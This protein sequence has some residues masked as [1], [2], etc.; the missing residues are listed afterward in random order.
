MSSKGETRCG[1]AWRPTR[2]GFT[3]IELLVVIGILLVLLAALT[4]ALGRVRAAARS[5]RC[6]NNLK[7]VTFDFTLFA[8]E[9]AHADRGDSERLYT[10]G[11]RL[12]DFQESI[13]GIDE[14]WD[15]PGEHHV[16][17]EPA[18]QP[19]MCPDG[20]QELYRNAG[21]PC[22]QFAV[23]P[24]E[25]VSVGFN[26]RL[27]RASVRLG[28]RW[29]LYPVSL[30]SRI[31]EHPLVPLV[32]DVDGQVAAGRRLAPYYSAPPVEQE[33]EGMYAAGRFWFPAPR[34]GGEVNVGFVGGHVLAAEQPQRKYTWDWS[35]QP[36]VDG[37]ARRYH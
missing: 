25:N 11:F 18:Q 27:H 26:M 30:G 8:D 15:V 17:L 35:Y 31:L 5:F 37:A 24:V 23:G 9:G 12:E 14:F 34:H 6:K 28:G 33:P 22:S 29:I 16:P 4:A 32:F 20:P 10:R 2:R 19:L 36:P 13:Y 21:L 3:L 7:T 1:A